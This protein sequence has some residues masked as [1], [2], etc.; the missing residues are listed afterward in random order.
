MEDRCVCCGAIV[1]E[2]EMVCSTCV[3]DVFSKNKRPPARLGWA[4]SLFRR[5]R[6]KAGSNSLH[7][8][9]ATDTVKNNTEKE[10]R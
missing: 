4:Q 10:E 3:V 1:P 8:K 6:K 2:G 7:K 9:T 5:H